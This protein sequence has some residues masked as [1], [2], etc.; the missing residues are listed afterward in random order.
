M[1]V[2]NRNRH[3]YFS[4]A[5]G[6]TTPRN[7]PFPTVHLLRYIRFFSHILTFISFRFRDTTLL[8]E[9]WLWWC[10]YWTHFN[11]TLIHIA[12][13]FLKRARTIETRFYIERIRWRRRRK[14]WFLPSI[15]WMPQK[16]PIQDSFTFFRFGR[17]LLSLSFSSFL[18]LFLS[19]SSNRFAFFDMCVS[20]ARYECVRVNWKK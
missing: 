19:M 16:N 13:H 17:F 1:S 4:L 18:L 12:Q 3:K 8:H 9:Q 15:N 14:T 2:S 6:Q 5:F 10:G 7:R 20:S 11:F